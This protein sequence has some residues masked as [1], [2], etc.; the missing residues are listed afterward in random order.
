LLNGRDAKIITTSYDFG[1]QHLLY[2]TS[3]VFT[4]FSQDSQDVILV[5]AYEGE[6]GEFAITSS[7]DKITV[8]G[9]DASVTSALSGTTLQINYQHPNGTTYINAAGQNGTDVLLV[10]AGYD[11]ATKWWAPLTSSGQTVMVQGP[12]LVR[13]AEIQ[14]SRLVL[15]GDTDATTSIEIVAPK[16]IK[17]VTWNGINVSVKRTS[18]GTLTGKIS[19]PNANISLPDLTKATWKYSPASPETNTTFDDSKWVAANHM[20]TTNPVLTPTTLPVLYADDYGMCNL[21]I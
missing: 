13:S 1:S 16:G 2:S 6:D 12:Y 21:C 3:E 10:V 15:T 5:Y 4:H 17:S 8:N 11:A 18:Y 7:S 20:T 14:G 19:G 9:T